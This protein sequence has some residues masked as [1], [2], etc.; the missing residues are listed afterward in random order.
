MQQVAAI[1]DH[2]GLQHQRYRLAGMGGY[3]RLRVL[4]FDGGDAG[5]GAG[6]VD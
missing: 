6:V 4:A 2:I 1:D 5:R 3:L